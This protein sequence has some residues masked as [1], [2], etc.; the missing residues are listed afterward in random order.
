MEEQNNNKR[1]L[2]IE[3]N[4]NVKKVSITGMGSDEKVVMKQEL[5]EEELDQ[6]TGGSNMDLIKSLDDK[7]KGVDY[8]TSNLTKIPCNIVFDIRNKK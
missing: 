2:N 3:L 4:D 7:E 8:P 1:M 5:D 6:A